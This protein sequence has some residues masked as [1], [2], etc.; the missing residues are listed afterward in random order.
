MPIDFPDPFSLTVGQLIFSKKKVAL[1]MK[2]TIK[3]FGD[4]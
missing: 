2:I 4:L 1:E 3:I